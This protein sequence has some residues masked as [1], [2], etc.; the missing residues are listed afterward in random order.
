MTSFLGENTYSRAIGGVLFMCFG[1]AQVLFYAQYT[2]IKE[3]I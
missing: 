3:K 1:V 2:Y